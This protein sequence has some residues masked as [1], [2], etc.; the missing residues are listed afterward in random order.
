MGRVRPLPQAYLRQIARFL[1][2]YNDTRPLR[3]AARYGVSDEYVRQ[4]WVRFHA[5]EMAP[6]GEALETFYGATTI[7]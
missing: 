2:V 7:R 3:I 1:Q 5:H 6:L 4:L